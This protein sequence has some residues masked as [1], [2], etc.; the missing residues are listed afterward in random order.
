M[1]LVE[2]RVKTFA[3]GE[4]G[5]RMKRGRDRREPRLVAETLWSAQPFHG[6]F[7]S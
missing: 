6:S 4:A 3:D 2:G 1:V 5:D 7:V